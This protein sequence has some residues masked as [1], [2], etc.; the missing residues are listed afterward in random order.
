MTDPSL[1]CRMSDH[2]SIA[3]GIQ[4]TTQIQS[5][6]FIPALKWKLLV[7]YSSSIKQAFA[8]TTCWKTIKNLP[9]SL[10]ICCSKVQLPKMCRLY[11]VNQMLPP[12]GWSLPEHFKAWFAQLIMTIS[13]SVHGGSS[14]G[15]DQR[16][17]SLRSIH[18]LGLHERITVR[19]GSN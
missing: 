14:I 2:R 18:L 5:R 8:I 16:G 19:R 9:R 15:S 17:K 4:Q 7:V 11:A 12:F 6:M 13:Y 1:T 10:T 3:V